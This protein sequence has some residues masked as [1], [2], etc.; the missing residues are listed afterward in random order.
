MDRFCR[1][2]KKI[3]SVILR[4]HDEMGELSATCPECGAYGSRMLPAFSSM[5]EK[6]RIE[7]QIKSKP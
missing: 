3:V 1:N 5:S 7:V 6:R 4:E 2:C